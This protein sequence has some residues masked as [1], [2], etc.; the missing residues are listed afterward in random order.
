MNKRLVILAFVVVT[1]AACTRQPAQN[2]E[3]VA[4]QFVTEELPAEDPASKLWQQAPEHH[5]HMLPQ[6]FT[7]PMLTEPG[8]ELVRVRALH[9]GEWVVF[10][11][12]WSDATQDLI[13]VTGRSC[14][15]A[16]IQFPVAPNGDVPDAAMGEQGKGVRIWYWKAVWQDDAARAQAGAGDRIASLYPN[17][18]IDHYPY[19]AGE[20]ARAEMEKRYA[21]AH[22]ASNPIIVRP[23]GTA[24]QVLLAEGF[25]NTRVI[26]S[27]SGRGHGQWVNGRW[28]TTIARPL[29]G[30][31]EV[32]DLA[33]DKRTYIALAIWDGS[34]AHTGSRKM[35]SEWI[36]LLLRKP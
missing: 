10:R 28:M 9:N 31:A 15:A 18:A 4:A 22:A 14:D 1:L 26:R 12:E 16:A 13:P 19:Q 30:G 36:P 20:A 23:Q 25:G 32:G 33:M 3:L 6:N 24:V 7:E 11:L 35:R 17:A 29:R 27:Q 5:A 21:P 34:K 8:V 2:Q